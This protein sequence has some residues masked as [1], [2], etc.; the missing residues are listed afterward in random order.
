MAFTSDKEDK[1]L[2]SRIEDLA[3]LSLTRNKPCFLG[4][5]NERE[6]YIIQ[7]N[8][9]FYSSYI[10]FYGGYKNA[11]RKILCFSQ[12]E[13]DYSLYPLRPIYFQFRKSDKLTHRDFLGAMM[14]L[15]VERDC[16]GD[17]VINEGKA[18]CFV[19]SEIKNYFRLHIS[20]IGRV[21]VK[22]VD[23]EPDIDYS[24]D[25]EKL[26]L[27]VSSMRLDVIVAA[28]TKLSRDKTAALILSGKVFTNY[29][30]NKK[31]SC[32]IKEE[33]II[34]IRGYGKFVI[35]EQAGNTKKGRIK[36]TVNKYR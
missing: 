11:K 29:S 18:V 1:E 7:E 27:I 33:D 12:N 19:K 8:F 30:E 34:S 4:F 36:I 28:I 3:D 21:G 20:K 15:G 22:I 13:E 17:I 10:S 31:V 26:S 5:L 25:I 32:S 9:L 24:D 23:D 35:K 14:N 6:Q 16:I 2:L